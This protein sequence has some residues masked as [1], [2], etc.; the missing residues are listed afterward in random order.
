MRGQQDERVVVYGNSTRVFR[1]WPDRFDGPL[2]YAS[3]HAVRRHRTFR[4]L[5]GPSGDSSAVAA[6]RGWRGMKDDDAPATRLRMTVYR[7]TKSGERLPLKT[8][9]AD[10]RDA[11]TPDF[12]QGWGPCCCQRCWAERRA[13]S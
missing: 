8:V 4:A 9:Q 11:R 13:T 3:L 10:S 7:I 2:H 6:G 12:S 5:A 1:L